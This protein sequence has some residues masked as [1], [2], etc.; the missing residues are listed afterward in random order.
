MS[1]K[2]R[3]L[4]EWCVEHGDLARHAAEALAAL[5]DSQVE[6]VRLTDGYRLRIDGHDVTVEYRSGSTWWP[7]NGD[8]E[9]I[10]AYRAGLA[11]RP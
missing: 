4:C 8:T 10:A 5:I 6:Y 11:R 2:D 9:V 7:S 3:D 1:S